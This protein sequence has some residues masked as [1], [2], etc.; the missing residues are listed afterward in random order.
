[1]MFY[2]LRDIEK[3]VSPLFKENVLVEYTIICSIY[4]YLSFLQYQYINY[5]HVS[6]LYM[7]YM[8]TS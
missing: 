1:M 8:G 3:M 5:Y 6:A 2:E 4:L 7:V